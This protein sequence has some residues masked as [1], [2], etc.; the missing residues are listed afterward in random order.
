MMEGGK[1]L[2]IIWILIGTQFYLHPKSVL[3]GIQIDW[4]YMH[5]HKIIAFIF[6]VLGSFI[7]YRNIFYNK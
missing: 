1:F 2:R 6:I 5:I 7:L 4:S 3:Y